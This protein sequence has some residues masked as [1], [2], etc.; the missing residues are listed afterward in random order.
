MR[1]AMTM[2]AVATVVM[3]KHHMS[4]VVNQ[5]LSIRDGGAYR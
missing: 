1:V 4:E 5:M 2:M 3:N